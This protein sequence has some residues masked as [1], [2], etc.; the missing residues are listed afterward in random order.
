MVGPRMLANF[1]KRSAGTMLP[2]NGWPVSGSRMG[3]VSVEK[4]PDRKA[5]LGTLPRNGWPWTVRRPSYA[6]NTKNLL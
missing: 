6:P 5:W 4:L 1:E 3:V 2:E